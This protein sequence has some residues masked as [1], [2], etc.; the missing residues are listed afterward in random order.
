MS[1]LNASNQDEV[2]RWVQSLIDANRLHDFYVSSLWINL[3]LDVLQD[4]KGECQHCKERGYYTKANIV[5]HV[6]YVKKHPHLALSKGYVFVVTDK[7]KDLIVYNLLSERYAELKARPNERDE[8]RFHQI[9]YL[10]NLYKRKIE[11]QSLQ[12][13]MKVTYMCDQFCCDCSFNHSSSYCHYNNFSRCCW[14]IEYQ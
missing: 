7:D 1:G 4:Y 9:E 5:H 13:S 14:T 3:R 2:G 6:Q 8:Y 10:Y 11:Q 12:R